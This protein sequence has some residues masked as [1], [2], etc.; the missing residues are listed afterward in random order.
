MSI[1]FTHISYE[2]KDL[3]WKEFEEDGYR[4]LLDLSPHAL[5]EVTVSARE[6]YVSLP[7]K[8]LQ[9]LK[10]AISSFTCIAVDDCIYVAGGDQSYRDGMSIDDHNLMEGD[11]ERVLNKMR[12]SS[13]GRY[14]GYS[15]KMYRY[16]IVHDTWELLPHRF[17]KR[18]YHTMFHYGNNLYIAGGKSLSANRRLEYLDHT[19]EIYD[20]RQDTIVTDPVNPHQAILFASCLYG[21][22]MILLGG[23]V[24]ESRSGKKIYTDQVHTLDLKSG[25]WYEMPSL[26]E[27]LETKGIRIG[28]K[29]YLVGGRQQEVLLNE[30]R[31]YSLTEGTLHKEV[32]LEHPVKYP[33]LATSEDI[34]Y[35]FEEGIMQTYHVNTSQIQAYKIELELQNCEMIVA[36]RKLFILGGLMIGEDGA[37][38]LSKGVYT[39]DLDEFL[40]TRSYVKR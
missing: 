10:E 1:S 8:F 9:S 7:Y 15:D 20:M 35:I 36:D 38:T 16:Y 27:G 6:L 18:A 33:A 21:D 29:M 30:I 19:I 28:D 39:I 3:S 31:S 32:Q 37:E 24:G 13:L 12:T 11:N 23:A 2:K 25:L 17:R 26:P 22:H 4:V 14:E 5:S 40:N 34:I